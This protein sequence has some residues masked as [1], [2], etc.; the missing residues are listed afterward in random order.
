M[1]AGTGELGP[2]AVTVRPV[3]VEVPLR[4]PC[5]NE[6]FPMFGIVQSAWN[7]PTD[8]I[9]KV[10]GSDPAITLA[11]EKVALDPVGRVMYF[12]KEIG[13]PAGTLSGIVTLPGSTDTFAV[14]PLYFSAADRSG[15]PDFVPIERVSTA[16]KRSSPSKLEKSLYPRST[17]ETF[18]AISTSWSDVTP[19]HVRSRESS[20][21]YPF[22]QVGEEIELWARF[23]DFNAGVP[24]KS[25]MEA[26]LLLDR[27][28][29]SRRG[30]SVNAENDVFSDPWMDR[31]VSSGAP[32]SPSVD[33]LELEFAR[34][35]IARV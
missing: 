27:S 15:I 7:P 30:R 33:R 21:G 31:D 1:P 24:E 18:E 3:R 17:D 6:M 32:L 28:T 10:L 4:V 35:S 25:G 12:S 22:F 2:F 5:E 8:C 19:F 11:P 14:I 23:T 29:F 9:T 13:A 16:A 26:S 20:P 34:E